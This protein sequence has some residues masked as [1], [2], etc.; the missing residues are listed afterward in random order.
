[1]KVIAICRKCNGT[2]TVKS[3]GMISKN[4]PVCKGK[5]KTVVK[6]KDLKKDYQNL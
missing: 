1:M 5:G 4:C 6:V 2:G 3:Y